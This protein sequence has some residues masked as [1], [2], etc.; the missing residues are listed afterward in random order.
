MC[1]CDAICAMS[2]QVP[3]QA[4]EACTSESKPHYALHVWN[5]Q[6]PA[7][8]TGT[9]ACL[10]VDHQQM[11][12]QVLQPCDDAS[13]REFT[14]Q[15]STLSKHYHLK[16]VLYHGPLNT[17]H[18]RSQVACT[19]P[20]YSREDWNTSSQ[21]PDF[22]YSNSSQRRG[23]SR[24]IAGPIPDSIRGKSGLL[25]ISL[26]DCIQSWSHNCHSTQ[27]MKWESILVDHRT[28]TLDTY[29]SPTAVHRTCTQVQL[30]LKPPLFRRS[31]L[32]EAFPGSGMLQKPRQV[33]PDHYQ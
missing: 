21:Y 22:T 18:L 12:L 14:S 19:G 5:N 33:C 28:R 26:D 23:T 11:H 8:T 3:A 24:C 25:S 29:L 13:F 30:A 6:Y 10:P 17:C 2:M 16:Y 27:R 31:V 20:C 4:F 7:F 9:A 15:E 1:A 32:D